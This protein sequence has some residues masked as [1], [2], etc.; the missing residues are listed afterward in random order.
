MP[1]TDSLTRKTE[2]T[3]REFCNLIDQIVDEGC[4]WLLFTGGEPFIRE[5]FLDI[6]IHAKKRGLLITLF[7]NGTFITPEIADYLVEWR[8]LSIE[9]TLYGR[10]QQTYE[11]VTGIKGSYDRCMHG[12]KLFHERNLPLILKSMVLSLNKHEVWEM[13]EYAQSLGVD[14][15]FDPLI[16]LGINGNTKPGDTRITV[17]EVVSLDLADTKRLKGWKEFC[18]KFL[19]PPPQPDYLYQCGA[20]IRSFHIDAYGQLSSCMMARLPAYDLRLGSFR[21]GWHTF[22]QDVIA[23]KWS[24][25][26]PCK[27][28]SLLS[29]CG[30][31][32]GW[33]QLEHGDQEEMVPYLCQIAH[34]RAQAFGL[35]QAESL[36]ET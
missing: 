1:A 6:Y 26:I 25:E 7:T 3:C 16:N 34:L 20:G 2:L 35:K 19:L 9:I 29:L 21:N 32:P 28:C 13:K 23:Q 17:D 31:C 36:I 11:T 12:I 18:E 8:P 33:A 24:K 15:H 5:D 22:M 27:T 30:R 14:F 10:T 4:F